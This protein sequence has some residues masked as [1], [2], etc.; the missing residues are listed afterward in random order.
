M[1]P[2]SSAIDFDAVADLY[3]SYVRVDFDIPFWL[4]ESKATS[5]RVLELACGTG[6]V[7]IPLL[8]VNVQLTCVDYSA[9]MLAQFQRKLREMGLAC[10][11]YLQDIADLELPDRFDLIFLPFHAFSE[12]LER[13]RQQRAL[14]RIRTHLMEHGMFICTLQ[15]PVVRTASMDG[16]MRRIGEFPLPDG[17]TVAV[18]TC[19]KFEEKTGIA[20]GDQLYEQYTAEKNLIDHRVLKVRFRLFRKDE[21]LTLASTCGYQVQELYGDYQRQPFDE[22]TSPFMIWKLRPATIHDRHL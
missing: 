13:R 16:V 6:R 8:K 20:S 15:N 19:L 3:D 17:G 7:S 2:A 1:N 12:I 11:V 9:G 21:F 4:G 14:Q 22:Q 5:G 18:S 10:P